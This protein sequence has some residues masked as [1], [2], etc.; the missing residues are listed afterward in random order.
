MPLGNIHVGIA[1][2][3]Y[4]DLFVLSQGTERRKLSEIH[5]VTSDFK[6]HRGIKGDYLD[7]VVGT[8]QPLAT[9]CAEETGHVGGTQKKKKGNR[10]PIQNVLQ[11]PLLCC[12]ATPAAPI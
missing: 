10:F 8:S 1:I 6:A 5:T 7:S 2:S 9:L 4:C 12:Q 3:S 11:S